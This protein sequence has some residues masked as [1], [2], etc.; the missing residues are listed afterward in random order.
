MSNL[1]ASLGLALNTQTL[2]K[3]D[4]QKKKVR[5]QFTELC[6]AAFIAVPG[7]GL[8]T[9]ARCKAGSSA[10]ADAALLTLPTSRQKHWATPLLQRQALLR[11]TKLLSL[12]GWVRALEGSM[13][14]GQPPVPTLHQLRHTHI[15]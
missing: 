1:L 12:A 6:W 5:A 3:T 2:T 8:D 13:G 9:F 15:L 7:C 11:R 10:E 4:E 14:K